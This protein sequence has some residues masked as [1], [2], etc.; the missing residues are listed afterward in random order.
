MPLPALRYG[1]GGTYDGESWEYR[2]TDSPVAPTYGS[3]LSKLNTEHF[4]LTQKFIL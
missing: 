3:K 2:D 1:L 4:G